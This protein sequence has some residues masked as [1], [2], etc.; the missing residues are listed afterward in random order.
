[1]EEAKHHLI[2]REPPGPRPSRPLLIVVSAPSG[3][4]KSTLCDRLVDEFPRITYSVSC[5]TRAPR[6]EEKDGQH[7]YFLSKKEFKERIKNGEFLEY[8][9]V[10]GNFYGTLE[11]TVVYAMEE[12]NHVLLDIDV[13]GVNQLR[14]SLVSMDPRNPVRRGFTD[15][16]ISPPSMEELEKR[17]RGRGTDEEKVIQK[18]LANASDE[19]ASAKEYTFQIVNDDLETAYQELKTVILSSLGMI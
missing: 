2:E 12:G 14:K 18:R 4:G 9:K 6:G 16:F 3:C 7:Y 15:I 1:M 8:A 17:L 5:T 11:D 13:Q 10:H 19:L